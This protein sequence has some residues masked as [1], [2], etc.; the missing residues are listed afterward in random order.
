MTSTLSHFSCL[1]ELIQVIYQSLNRFVLI[2]SVD[3]ERWMVRL[4][5]TSEGRWWTGSWNEADILSIIGSKPSTTL[6]EKFAQ[7][8]AESVIQGEIYVSNWSPSPGTAIKLTLAPD[9]KK[10]MHIPLAEMTTADAVS[11]ATDLLL[12]IALQ[13]QSRKCQLHGT[14]TVSATRISPP[15]ITPSMPVKPDKGVVNTSSK[16]DILKAQASSSHSKRKDPEPE[17]KN[18]SSPEPGPKQK[19][20]AAPR[21][22]KGA[23]LA[24]PNKKARKYQAIEFGSDED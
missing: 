1:D 14:S 24:N 17:P 15:T 10:P 8:L 13:A 16:T 2:S 19:G 23:S 4:G 7:K 11:F 12:D 5:L 21:P 3:E 18:E 6:L 20:K 9:S 22:M